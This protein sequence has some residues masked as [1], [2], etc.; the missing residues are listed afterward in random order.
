MRFPSLTTLLA[1][2]F[3]LS[4]TAAPPPPGIVTNVT[5][6]SNITVFTPPTWWTSHSTSY[7]RVLLLNQ[8]CEKNNVLLTTFIINPPGETYLPIYRSV[9]GGFTWA[10]YSQ[11]YFDDTSG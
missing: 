8:A 4:V 10:Y 5:I 7:A 9:D 6:V 2:S 1:T 11:I 3:V